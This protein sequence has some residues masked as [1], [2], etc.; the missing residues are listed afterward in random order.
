MA[1]ANPM[2]G[3]NAPATRSSDL[4]RWRTALE[5]RATSSPTSKRSVSKFCYVTKFFVVQL[6]VPPNAML[7][8]D[9]LRQILLEQKKLLTLEEVKI[10][11]VPNSKS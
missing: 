2:I 9:F 8:K 6:Y 4:K 11:E 7:N 1:E 3:K 5:R 10:V